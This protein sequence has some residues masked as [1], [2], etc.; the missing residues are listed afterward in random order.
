[1]PITPFLD[2][3]HFDAEAKRVMGVAFESTIAA[4][5]LADR[6]DPVVG[7]V[8]Q[9]IIDLAKAGEHNP[10]ALC[11]RALAELEN[12]PPRGTGDRPEQQPSQI[13]REA[14]TRIPGRPDLYSCSC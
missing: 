9:K 7:I 1:M 3:E 8:A 11:E 13:Q 14:G 6:S 2:G 4:L 5:R 10:D 12:A